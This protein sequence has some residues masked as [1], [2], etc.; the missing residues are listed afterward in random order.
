MPF[1]WTASV[2]FLLAGSPAVALGQSVLPDTGRVTVDHSS[3]AYQR[4]G[5]GPTV[6]LLHANYLDRR[7][8]D[9]Q[10]DQLT[11]YFDVVRYDARGLGRSGP[12]R[13]GYNQADDLYRLLQSLG[14]R[15]A[16]LVG[17][18]LGGATALDFTVAHPE[19][20]T[21]LVLVGSG[22]SGFAWSPVDFQEPWRV[23]ARAALAQGDTTAVPLAW[24]ESDF[25][26]VA[27]ADPVARRTLATLLV[28]NVAFWKGLIQDQR[29]WDMEPRPPA[30]TALNSIAVPVLVV[31]GDRDAVEVRAIADTLVRRIPGARR[32]TFAGADHFPTIERPDQFA[33]SL[34]T[35]LRAPR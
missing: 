6:V 32:I 15:R 25:T 11:R 2:I 19:M 8:W 30:I 18:S 20:V 17:A 33:D 5:S 10:F 27:R 7:M 3:L 26:T 9:P 14:I 4:A 16:T 22:L 29:D 24:L 12:A 35:F 1:R 21:A 13:V 34:L 28:E 23:Q 31:I